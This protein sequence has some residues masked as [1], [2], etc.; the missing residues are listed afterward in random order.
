MPVRHHLYR[1]HE[2]VLRSAP[3]RPGDRLLDLES[4]S[5]AFT[6]GMADQ[7][8]C[9]GELVAIDFASTSLVRAEKL[10]Q[11]AEQKNTLY[12]K[13]VQVAIPYP[14]GYFVSVIAF[15]SYDRF[16]QVE[17]VLDEVWR[18]L[19]PKAKVYRH[20]VSTDLE[21]LRD[22]LAQLL[23]YGREDSRAQ[24]ALNWVPNKMST[25]FTIEFHRRWTQAWGKQSCL[26][27]GRK[28]QASGAEGR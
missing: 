13:L 17:P 24:A 15:G 14:D 25:Y 1:K 27:V 12:F 11:Q 18:V 16:P 28:V 21:G 20:E 2:A 19:K 7:L 8:A 6:A 23:F 22:R 4:N 5:V 10:F 9:S 3:I 26:L